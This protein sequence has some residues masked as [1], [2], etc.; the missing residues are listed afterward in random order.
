MGVDGCGLQLL[1][2]Q[3]HLDHADIDLA[4]KQMRGKAVA[5]GVGS[6]PLVDTSGLGRCMNGAVELTNREGFQG[7][8]AWEQPPAGQHLALG[9]GQVPPRAK[10]LQ[11][12]RAEHGVAVLGALALLHAQRHALA[13][14]IG[15]PQADDLAG[16]KTC[17]IGDRQG[18]LVLDVAGR[19]QKA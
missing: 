7:R 9:M 14:H 19:S 3:Q 8:H 4:L 13:V 15:D 11:Q 18:H 6:D 5:Q 10:A 12:N 17:T 16:A 2:P 1:V